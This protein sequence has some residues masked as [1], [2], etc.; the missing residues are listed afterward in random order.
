[1]V[2]IVIADST[3]SYDGSH[4]EARPLGGTES[5]VIRLAEALARRGH[6]VSAYTNCEQ[7]IEHNSV[8]WSPLKDG[9][10]PHCDLYVAVQH[11]RLLGFVRRPRRRALWVIWR[12][13]NLKHYKQLPLMWWYRPVPVFASMHQVETLSPFL[14]PRNPNI[15]IPLALPDDVRGLG[16]LPA[17]PPPEA[18]FASNPARDLIGLVDLW[19]KHIHPRRPDALLHVYGVQNLKPEDDPWQLWAGSLLPTGLSPSAM[20]S[21]RVHVSASRIELMAAMRRARMMLYLGH[22]TEAYCLSLAECQALGTPA[23]VA[24]VAVLPERVLDGVTGFVHADPHAFAD[25]ALALFSDDALWRRQHE[26]CLRLQQ[27]LSWDEFAARYE[28]A[29]LGD[30]L[31]GDRA[32]GAALDHRQVSRVL[33]G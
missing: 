8:V 29:L 21:V 22:K 19:A 23:V 9:G 18:I 1:M 31:L 14:P 7:R 10:P 12:P 17:P 13:N 2:S 24:P 20:A 28:Q 32:P 30:W 11:P 25:A 26:A 5:S 15:V 16:P 33:S 4:L 3:R 27:L 6:S